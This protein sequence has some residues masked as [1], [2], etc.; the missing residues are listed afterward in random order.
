MRWLD[1]ITDSMDMSLCKLQELVMDRKPGVLWSMG[2]QRVGH[3][4]ATELNWDNATIEYY[5]AF[6][7]KNEFKMYAATRWTLKIKWNK[8]DIKGQML[9]DSTDMKNLE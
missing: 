8:L 7:K 4:W 3:N 2:L 9:Y 5:L 6:Y 1:G